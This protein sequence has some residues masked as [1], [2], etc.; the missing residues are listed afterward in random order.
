MGIF[1]PMIGS[2]AR[3]DAEI[4]ARLGIGF[5]VTGLGVSSVGS[6]MHGYAAEL[7]HTPRNTYSWRTLN[8][9][10]YLVAAD[11]VCGQLHGGGGYPFPRGKARS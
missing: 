10:V 2:L 3:T 11:G 6:C 4:G 5:A 7:T 9:F 8:R 1:A